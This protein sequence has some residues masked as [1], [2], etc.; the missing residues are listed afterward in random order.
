[1]KIKNINASFLVLA[2]LILSSFAFYVGAENNSNGT[3]S[4]FLDSDQDGL[5]DE[6]EK[7][8]GTDPHNPDTDGDGYSDGAEV[9]SGY[10][11]LKKAPGDKLPGFNASVRANA[12]DTTDSTGVASA[13]LGDTSKKN[14]TKDIAQKISD[15]AQTSATSNTPISLDDLQATITPALDNSTISE[16]DLPP[17][18]PKE[19]KIK[20][21]NYANLGTEKAKAKK[22]ED[23]IDYLTAIAFIFTSNSPEPVTKLPDATNMFSKITTAITT[24]ITTQ[25]NSGLKDL[26]ASQQKVVEQLRAVEVPEDLVDIHVKAMRFA[27]YS[28]NLGT[29]L[30]TKADDPMTSIANLSKL[31][32]FLSVFSDFSTEVENKLAE[33]DLTYDEAV[34]NKL[35][36]YGIDAP[37]DLSGLESLIN[38]NTT[39]TADTTT[40]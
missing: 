19:V 21:Q 39:A 29:L 15:L 38:T 34:Q 9:R 11:P 36:S 40:P 5:S 35:K 2:I 27:L 20:K 3:K 32:G 30:Q 26:I 1:M 14:L 23:C 22:K 28:E 4:I 24:A 25:S 17:Y 6:E 33:Y 12:S 13:V 10:D 8:Y 7:I 31:Q 16:D 37:K 18:D